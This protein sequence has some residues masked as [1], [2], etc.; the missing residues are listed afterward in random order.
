MTVSAAEVWP[1]P[2]HKGCPGV[3]LLSSSINIKVIPLSICKPLC[4]AGYFIEWHDRSTYWPTF[5]L[6][7]S[8]QMNYRWADELDCTIKKVKK[9]SRR[10][11]TGDKTRLWNNNDIYLKKVSL[12]IVHSVFPNVNSD[13]RRPN[14]RIISP[15]I[16]R[17]S[18]SITRPFKLS[19]K[20]EAF[21][22][23]FSIVWHQ[24]ISSV[25]NVHPSQSLALKVSCYLR[26]FLRFYLTKVKSIMEFVSR[27]AMF[28]KVSY[29]DLSSLLY[30]RQSGTGS[31]QN[32][33]LSQFLLTCL[34]S[35]V[36]Y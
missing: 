25:G 5:C 18:K 7:S 4:L 31:S 1:L 15:S 2:K 17:Y 9:K 3:T 29:L 12:Q 34:L 24:A 19:Y 21:L 13:R 22:F 6:W 26:F 23:S 33:V 36:W 10:L 11:Q 16:S 30:L 32:I 8:Q 20:L 28:S 27:F 14:S 35:Q